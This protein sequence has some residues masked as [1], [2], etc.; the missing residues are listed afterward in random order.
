[1]NQH[2]SDQEVK[3]TSVKVFK[4]VGPAVVGLSLLAMVSKVFGFAEKV[5]IANY[6]GTGDGADVY[7][8]SMGIVLSIVWLVRELVYPSL[9]P[10]YSESLLDSEGMSAVLLRKVLILAVVF[11]SVSVILLLVFPGFVAD[12]LLPGF[13]A[14]KSIATAGLLRALSISVLFWGVMMVTYTALIGRKNFFAAAWPEAALK[15]FVVV[16]I[17][18]LLPVLGI[19]SLAVALGIGTLGC[20]L[21][22]FYYLPESRIL[23]RRCRDDEGTYFGRV[24]FLMG[25][26]V[27]GVLFSH[28]S[29]IIDNLLASTLPSGQLSYLGY[30]K[31]LVDAVLLAGPVALVTVV[32]S[33]L[34]ALSSVGDMDRFCLLVRRSLR[35]VLYLVIPLSFVLIVLRYDLIS[36][37]FQ[38]GR[39]GVE[40][41]SGTSLVLGV[42]CAGLVTFA[43]DGLLVHCFYALGETKTPVKYGVVFVF[44]DIVLALVFLRPFEYVGIAAALVISKTMKVLILLVLLNK[45]VGGLFGDRILLF[46]SKIAIIS[47]LMCVTIWIVRVPVWPGL[48]FELT[49]RMLCAL[50][51]FLVGSYLLGVSEFWQLLSVVRYRKAGVSKLSEKM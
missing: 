25:P 43:L 34:S 4:R 36:V 3:T 26:L 38:R 31:K 29:G 50:A 8:A 32:Y 40:S 5:V 42:Y 18:L 37:L 7:F 20:V 41:V 39:F 44:V 17:V 19:Y 6:F 49:V 24:L 13:S 14:S 2:F 48:V 12:F 15:L 27:I 45:R 51:V 16:G 22:H 23:F 33:H 28:I 10:I 35:L 9:L 30:S 1:M 47:G 11:L 21:V 46:L